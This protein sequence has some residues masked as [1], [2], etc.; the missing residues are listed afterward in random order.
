MASIGGSTAPSGFYLA[1]SKKAQT[2]GVEDLASLILRIV[3]TLLY[4]E[5]QATCIASGSVT[6]D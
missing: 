2:L 1:S 3:E 5:C 4:T 6:S